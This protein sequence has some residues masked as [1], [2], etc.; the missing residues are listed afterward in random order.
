MRVRPA[1]LSSFLAC[2]CACAS[3]GDAGSPA[4]P[5]VGPGQTVVHTALG[6]FIL[7]YDID[8]TGTEGILSEALTQADGRADVAVETFDQRTGAILRILRQQQ[9][10]KNDF[11]TLGVFGAHVALTEFEHVSGLYVDRR[12]Y[13]VSNP[14]DANRITGHWTPPFAKATDIIEG[15]AASVGV[16]TALF[17]GFHNTANDFHTYLF[18]S[19]VAANTFG[20]VIPVVGD[21]VFDWNNSPAVAFDGG[22]NQAVLGSS[23]G[24]YLCP[25][26]I[27]QVDLATGK[28]Q[29]FRGLG[30]GFVNGIAVDPNTHVAATT[31]EDD[32]SVEFYNLAKGTSLR[33]VLP[34]ANSQ[35]YSGGAVAVDPLHRLFL[36]GQEFSSTAP[37]GSSIHVFDEKGRLVESLN[38]FSLPASPAY[39][40]LNPAQRSGFVIVT[41][42]LT[43]LQ[44]FTY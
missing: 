26:D 4:R 18:T 34:G 23:P 3:A 9:D 17:F 42:D 29:F 24:C 37:S 8:P 35:L 20:P 5:A 19:D 2:A 31:S 30:T 14:I 39:M 10:S 11:A 27:G 41:P 25:I 15:G 13:L 36:V 22:S 28:L 16:D 40:A 38:G 1:I 33:V 43:S 44:S 12:S 21:D 7:G 32:F 6:G